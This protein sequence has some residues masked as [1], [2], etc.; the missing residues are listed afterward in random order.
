MYVKWFCDACLTK[1]EVSKVA[2]IEDKYGEL[3]SQISKMA[4]ALSE[5]KKD[6]GEMKSSAVQV[7]AN[8]GNTVTSDW[9]NHSRVKSMKASLMIKQKPG[10]QA[11]NF[12]KLREIA[13]K[14]HIP[15]SNVGVSQKG[16]TF[17]QCPTPEDRDKLQ[18]LIQAD[19]T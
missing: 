1:F 15:V 6:V 7:Q 2:T 11:P 19:F 3:V 4:D 17:I 16:N 8:T 9:S 5:V 13:V 18:P 12:N 14:N 10:C